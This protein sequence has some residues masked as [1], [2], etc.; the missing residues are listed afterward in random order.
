MVNFAKELDVEL[1][2]TD[3]EAANRLPKT[4][5]DRR[6]ATIIVQFARRKRDK[7]FATSHKKVITNSVV[8]R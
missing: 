7:L 3:T 2:E 8:S 5:N 6:S 1:L 4:H